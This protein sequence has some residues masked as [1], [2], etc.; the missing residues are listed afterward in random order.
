M[1]TRRRADAATSCRGTPDPTVDVGLAS[2]RRP[3]GRLPD[4]DT[5]AAHLVAGARPQV[6][7]DDL[8]LPAVPLWSRAQAIIGLLTGVLSIVGALYSGVSYLIAPKQGEVAALVRESR[9]DR[10]VSDAI[11]EVLTP[12][13][14]LV[15]T[16]APAA[17]GWARHALQPGSYHV[18]VT[19]PGF[20]VDT[21][22]IQV[23][24]GR[25]VEV[26]FQLTPRRGGFA[27][28]AAR[29]SAGP[30]SRF[31]GRLGL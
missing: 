31:F 23:V 27:D 26:R 9:T 4:A 22:P 21:K 5:S 12:G 3:E 2:T 29:G 11:V 28:E 17:D 30:V 7:S 20:G 25:T 13:D 8:N 6:A 15:T 1:S 19:R 18:R 14:T 24:P 10:P 16:L